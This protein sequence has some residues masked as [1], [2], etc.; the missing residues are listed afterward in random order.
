[1]IRSKFYKLM[2]SLICIVAGSLL[3]AT[4][5]SFAAIDEFNGPSSEQMHIGEVKN[6]VVLY[7]RVDQRT[8]VTASGTIVVPPL[9]S[10]TDQRNPDDW[11]K[12]TNAKAVFY[13]TKDLE[14]V[15]V[16]ISE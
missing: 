4:T 14:M 3:L 5:N 11:Y 9:V 13:F 16:V 12:K 6:E 8:L 10:L 1:M 2:S 7:Q 15:R